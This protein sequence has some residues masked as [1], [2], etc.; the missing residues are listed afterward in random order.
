MRSTK[1]SCVGNGS[2]SWRKKSRMSLKSVF[3]PD[4]KIEGDRIQIAGDEHHHLTVA[5]VAPREI[6]EVFNGK[7]DVWTA[8][9]SELGRRETSA[10]ISA[11]RK[12]EPDTHEIVLA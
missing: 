4:P 1:K 3:L 12:V 8:A 9:I 11:R 2:Q 5:R 10:V 6:I 7:G